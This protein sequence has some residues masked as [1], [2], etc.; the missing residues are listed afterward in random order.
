[1]SKVVLYFLLYIFKQKTTC[2]PTRDFSLV[3]VQS[4]IPFT[5]MPEVQ[6]LVNIDDNRSELMNR[7]RFLSFF[8]IKD[9]KRVSQGRPIANLF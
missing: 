6:R 4:S 1:M 7:Y 9:K 3:L 5:E 2:S 8:I